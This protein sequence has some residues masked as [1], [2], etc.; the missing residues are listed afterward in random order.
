MK[1]NKKLLLGAALSLTFLNL[2]SEVSATAQYDGIKASLKQQ[3]IKNPTD[4]DAKVFGATAT[5]N[6]KALLNKWL[7]A[8]AA[9]KTNADVRAAVGG[10]TNAEAAKAIDDLMKA[11]G[12][13]PPPPPG[14][15][16]PPP[17]PPP[18]AAKVY[19]AATLKAAVGFP[20][21]NEA[22]LGDDVNFVNTLTADEQNAV[23]DKMKTEVE[24]V[25]KEPGYTKEML[26]DFWDQNIPYES[27]ELYKKNVG[28][29]LEYFHNDVMSADI[30]EKVKAFLGLKAE[31]TDAQIKAGFTAFK[32]NLVAKGA[33][34]PLLKKYY[35]E[36]DIADLEEA[37]ALAP[38]A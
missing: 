19:T 16:P 25:K 5:A 15:N 14:G 35:D 2:G 20:E 38:K 7:A 23:V 22:A 4:E 26:E 31:A 12:G 13:N 29:G 30:E 11:P 10:K 24:S 6:R 8:Q 32:A 28:K 34:S 27:W 18:P 17:P 1:I 3:G 36:I 37:Y 9:G 21:A 33:A